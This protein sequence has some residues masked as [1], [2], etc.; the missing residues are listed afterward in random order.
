[1]LQ[2]PNKAA[3]IFELHANKDTPIVKSVLS[4]AEVMIQDA[5]E[6]NDTANL[7]TVKA[8]Q[9]AIVALKILLAYI[10]RGLPPAG[11]VNVVNK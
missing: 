8:N 2:S 3:L 4:L 6:D 7:D 9:G 1:M 11:V 5:R 10:N